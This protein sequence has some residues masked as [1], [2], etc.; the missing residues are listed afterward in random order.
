MDV[1]KVVRLVNQF[2]GRTETGPWRV[3]KSVRRANTQ[4]LGNKEKQSIRQI[5][6]LP[7]DNSGTRN[8]ELQKMK[9]DLCKKLTIK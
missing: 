1:D 9:A 2:V 7:G 8:G 4:N 5:N 6:D 3:P